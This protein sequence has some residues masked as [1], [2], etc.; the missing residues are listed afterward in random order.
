LRDVGSL[1]AWGGGGDSLSEWTRQIGLRL[2]AL[3]GES[4]WYSRC[5]VNCRFFREHTPGRRDWRC[6]RRADRGYRLRRIDLTD[7]PYSRLADRESK[8]ATEP[9]MLKLLTRVCIWVAHGTA[10]FNSASWGTPNAASRGRLNA[11][12]YGQTV[13]DGC[14]NDWVDRSDEL[15]FTRERTAFPFLSAVFDVMAKSHEP[16]RGSCSTVACAT[17]AE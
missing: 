3:P 15:A 7:C 13:M 14:M 17:V 1:W 16:T 6:F 11:A 2:R 4:H 9:L 5:L 12:S 8:R 10:W